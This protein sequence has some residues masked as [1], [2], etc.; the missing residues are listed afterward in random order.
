MVG[1]PVVDRDPWNNRA[2]EG[3]SFV[4][5]RTGRWVRYPPGVPVA[6]FATIS[7]ARRVA[8]EVAA[9]FDARNLRVTV[10]HCDDVGRL[11]VICTARVA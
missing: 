6:K 3:E 4:L 10:S 5:T 9:R 7:H 8:A 1:E 2:E 11:E